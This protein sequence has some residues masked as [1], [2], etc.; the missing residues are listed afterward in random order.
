MLGYMTKK[1]A[2]EEGFTHHG[3][4]RFLPIWFAEREGDPDCALVAAK[5][6]WLDWLFYPLQWWEGFMHAING[7]EPTFKFKVGD[8]I[9]P[10]GQDIVEDEEGLIP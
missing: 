10:E 3:Y 2:L 1:E 8:P 7:T 5:I 9:L 6:A 4:Y